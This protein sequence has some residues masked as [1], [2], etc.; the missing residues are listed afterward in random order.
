VVDL[1]DTAEELSSAVTEL[2]QTSNEMKNTAEEVSEKNFK[3]SEELNSMAENIV[4]MAN[5]SNEFNQTI[6]EIQEISSLAKKEAL[7][8]EKTGNMYLL[9]DTEG[10]ALFL[11]AFQDC[12][13]KRMDKPFGVY[14]V[15]TETLYLDS[16]YDQI[17]DSAIANP[18]NKISDDAP[19]CR[20][21]IG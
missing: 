14:V 15:A 21:D 2:D 13:D 17:I 5:S 19:D 3:T 9:G 18:T 8:G 20:R 4:K 7:E 6:S 1:K 12:N 10:Q 16:N 11:V